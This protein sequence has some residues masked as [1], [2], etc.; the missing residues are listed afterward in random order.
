MTLRILLMELDELTSVSLTDC[1]PV[2]TLG[3][4][5]WWARGLVVLEMSSEN[6]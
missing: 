1:L 3:I 5:G 4:A 2:S 6:A